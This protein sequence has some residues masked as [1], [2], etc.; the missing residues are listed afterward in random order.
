VVFVYDVSP[1]GSS[2]VIAVGGRRDDGLEHVEIVDHRSGT[3]WLVDRLVELSER[4]SPEEIAC[5]G[6]NASAT[7]FVAK[8]GDRGVPVEEVTAG[9]HAESCSGLVNAIRDATFRHLG[10]PELKTAIKGAAKRSLGDGWLWS[11]KDSGADIS[12]LVALS[13]ARRK[14][15]LMID[16]TEP[17][18]AWA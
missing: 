14:A 4:H 15:E 12:P 7:Q 16:N 2:A 18:A 1:D 17:M 11:R 8:L 13:L 6:R 10:Q 5:D 3:A 9:E